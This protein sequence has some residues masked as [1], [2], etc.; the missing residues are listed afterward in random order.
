MFS[1]GDAE[2]PRPHTPDHYEPFARKAGEPF[3]EITDV[4]HAI[5]GDF[6][7]FELSVPRLLFLPLSA[8]CPASRAP[9]AGIT[10]KTTAGGASAM[11]GVSDRPI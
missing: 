5:M 9:S 7:D 6:G 4:F 11:G 10:T 2:S 1:R 3:T 8:M